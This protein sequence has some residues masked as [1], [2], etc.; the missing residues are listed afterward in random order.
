MLQSLTLILS[1]LALTYSLVGANDQCLL[2]GFNPSVLMCDTCEVMHKIIDHQESYVN[3]KACCIEKVDE[4][5]ELAIMEVDKRYLS[6]MKEISSIIDKKAEL[7]LKVRYRYGSPV[8]QMYKFKSDS[9]PTETISINSWDKNTIEDYLSSHLK[10]LAK[11]DK[12]NKL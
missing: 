3:C 5:Y 9:E 10:M 7:H 8:L 4:K 12:G 6:Y 11:Y 2:K 1:L